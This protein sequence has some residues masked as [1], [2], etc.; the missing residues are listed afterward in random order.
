MLLAVL[1]KRGGFSLSTQDIYANI[2][3]GIRITETAAD[4]AILSA[5]V[6]SYVGKIFPPQT[7]VFG[8]VGLSG[9]IR[10]VQH[11]ESRLRE[12]S[13]LGFH[14]AVTPKLRNPKDLPK[15]I[16]II[17]IQNIRELTNL[18]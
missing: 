13:K 3:G 1:E 5:V 7:V 6:S 10:N 8:E 18:F 9:E 2:V 4:L 12:A 15:G 16:E 11:I 17:S 14:K